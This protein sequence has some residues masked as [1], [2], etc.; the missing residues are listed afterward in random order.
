MEARAQEVMEEFVEG[1]KEVYRERQFNYEEQWPPVRGNRLISL[2]L[3]EADKTEGFGG[4]SPCDK[5]KHTPI[6][7]GDLFEVEEGKKPVR[8]LIVEG[9][10]GTGKT[11]LCTMLAEEWANGEIF[12]QFDCFLLLPLKNQL[13]DSASSLPDLLTLYHP[14]ETV[15]GS[16]VQ[17]LKRTKGKNVLIVADGWDELC[18]ESRSKKSFIYNLLFG[19]LL[20]SVTILLTSRPYASAPLHD[21][22][23]VD[24]LVEVVGFNEENIK[25]YI[26]SEFEKCPE[27]AFTLIEQLENNPVI[28][29][30][31]SV[32]LNCAIICNLWHTLDRVLPRTL[33]ELYA[34]I[35]LNVI[36]RS[37]R[38]KYDD[39]PISLLSFDSIPEDFQDIFWLT[40][41]F[42]FECLSRN[43]LVFLEDELALFFPRSVVLHMSDKFLCFGLLQCA[44]SLL[45]VGRGLSFHFVHLTIQEFLAALHLI[46]LPNEEKLKVCETYANSDRF[47]MVWRF[48]FGLGCREESS[49]SRKAVLLN[50]HVVD[51][52]LS[53]T[54]DDDL[55]LLLCH[56]SI[57]SSNK[58][59]CLK[60]AKQ[61]S[62]HFEGLYSSIAHTPHDCAAVLHVLR[63]TL[64]C[65]SLVIK[66]AHCGLTDKLLKALT[67]IL[68]SAGGKLQVKRLSFS[69]NKLTNEGITDLF[70]RAS[71]SVSTIESIDL[72]SNS[73]TDMPKIS[74]CHWL[75]YLSLSNNCLGVSGIMSLET[76]VQAGELVTVRDLSL[77][78]TLTD[79]T[80]INGA[81]LATL[82]PSIASHCPCLSWLNLSKN[83]LGTPGTSALSELITSS[84]RSKLDLDLSD[85]NVNAESIASLTI[86]HKPSEPSYECILNFMNNPI[87]YNG[88]LEIFSMLRGESCPITSLN[89][90]NTDLTIPVKQYYNLE[91]LTTTRVNLG[92]MLDSSRL[93]SLYLG[94]N[95]FSGDNVLLLAECM[96]L[97]KSLQRLLCWR[98]SLTSTEVIILLGHLKSCGSSHK[99]LREW[100][101]NNNSIDDEGTTAL[102]DSLPELFPRLESVSLSGNP[103][104]GEVKERLKK[105]QEV[106]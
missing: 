3:V 83:S 55:R 24:R 8:K 53:K 19:R 68:S 61:I 46:T 102:I 82:L 54:N 12:T 44:R 41:K 104:S 22:P 64:R 81:L 38:K 35:V 27:K 69:S 48:M 33:T 94:D 37:Y 101:L 60:I 36:L 96:R 57:E 56:C 99:S 26:E 13:I 103:V 80:D 6:R 52:F 93:R 59:V 51:R 30:V 1:L 71:D 34:Q 25:Q 10:A 95:K 42:A 67:N 31:C 78:N 29:A 92:P 75:T 23:T 50:D 90:G 21:L 43:R 88:L 85:T 28:Q 106:R 20:P 62:G 97:C 84:D 89:L 72:S 7:H 4:G 77:S 49:Y 2:Q 32:P 40:C 5:L 58:V 70:V 76:A 73:I 45:P 39:S 9:N 47:A 87:R 100:D 65:S 63:H 14:D 66:L 105:L 18:E 15:C 79:D 16:V 74:S 11:T 91:Q 17:Q 86:A 98:C